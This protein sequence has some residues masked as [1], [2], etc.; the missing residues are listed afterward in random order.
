MGFRTRNDIKVKQP[1]D[2]DPLTSLDEDGVSVSDKF[3]A[4]G[5]LDI[6]GCCLNINDNTKHDG[7]EGKPDECEEPVNAHAGLDDGDFP[8]RVAV[9]AVVL[10]QGVPLIQ[11]L[12]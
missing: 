5:D 3:P 11:D 9:L 7:D 1:L 4:V 12:I 6:P 8:L 2:L 10:G